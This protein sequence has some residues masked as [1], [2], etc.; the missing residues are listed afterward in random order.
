MP[1]RYFETQDL[2]VKEATEEILKPK[3]KILT[4]EGFF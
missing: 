4:P 3:R 1:F 2:I